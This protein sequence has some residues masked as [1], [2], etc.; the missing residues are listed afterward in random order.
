MIK[1]NFPTADDKV[2]LTEIKK[3]SLLLDNDA[4]PVFGLSKWV[5]KHFSDTNDILYLAHSIP[6][7]IADFFGDFVQGDVDGMIIESSD[8]VQNDKVL[9]YVDYN[10]LKSMIYDIAYDQS[11]Y[12]YSVLLGRKDENDNFIIDRIPQDQVF[13]A[14]DK[15]IIFGSYI[16]K[17][18]S[19]DGKDMWLYT[20][21][22][23]LKDN[24]ARVERKLYNTDPEG[25]TS[26][27]VSLASYD[28]TLLPEENLEIDELPIAIVHNSRRKKKEFAKSDLIDVLPQID[29]INERSTQKAIQFTKNLDAK[30]VLP[31]TMED[32]D[33]NV[34]PFD[35]VTTEK[36][37]VEPKYLTNANPLLTDISTHCDKELAYI[38]WITSVPIFELT[39]SGVPERVESLRIKLFQAVRKTNSKRAEVRKGIE[40]MLRVALKFDKAGEIA[41]FKISFSEVLPTDPLV[42]V[43]VEALKLTSGVS[44]KKES[45][46]RLE[47]V[48]DET[49][50]AEIRAIEQENK[51]AGI[52]DKP[53]NFN[54]NQQV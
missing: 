21:R 25:I 29:E 46:K 38:S 16:I 33:G 10:D 45:I 30:L 15:S 11:G 9:E 14:P 12:G 51:I 17:P 49:A 31:K 48:D 42:D 52:G 44:S 22:Y 36:E 18:N 19:V 23:F 8:K 20:Q 26:D 40:T 2:R 53:I 4:Y 54:D 35:F 43:Q 39:G 13:I 5:L 47:N 28:D 1:H 32:D 24:T 37:D 41:P 34:Q 27:E 6:D 50:L 3:L 7:K